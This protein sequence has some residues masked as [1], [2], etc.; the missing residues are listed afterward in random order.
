MGAIEHCHDQSHED[1]ELQRESGVVL[2]ERAGRD[3]NVLNRES[4][5][6]GERRDGDEQRKGRR[7]VAGVS[8][9]APSGSASV[10]AREDA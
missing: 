8:T 2:R 7:S 3:E 10:T 5:A 9:R 1:G 4:T 6:E